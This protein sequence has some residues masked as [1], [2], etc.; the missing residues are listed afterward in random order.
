MTEIYLIRH[1][2]AE[3]NVFRMMQ[4]QWDGDVTDMGVRQIDALAE[5]LKDTHFGAVYS[6]DLYRTRLTA[7]A[8]TRFHD[9]PF[10]TT[11]NLREI[12]VGPWE[13]KYFAEL[14]H[15]NPQQT[16]SF[17]SDPEHWYLEGAE[18]YKDVTER[19]YPQ[20]VEIAEKHPGE[21]VAAVSHGITIRCAL[22]KISGIALNDLEHL[23]ICGNTA[24]TK[25]IYEDGKFRIDFFNDCSH[26]DALGGTG[27]GKA[28]ALRGESFD[29]VQDKD[30]YQDCYRDAWIA[31]HGSSEGYSNV[32]LNYAIEHYREDPEA[33]LRIYDGDKLVGLVDMDTKRGENAGYGWISLLYLRPEYRH[34][35]FG[36]QLLAR[37]LF[38]Y[39]G[40]GR[41]ALRL[42]VAEDNEAALAFY[43]KN[44]F[45]VLSWENG[46]LGKLL[47]MEKKLGGSRNEK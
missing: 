10:I 41:K 4:G 17:I 24:V 29:P 42:Q 12:N 15:K 1:A 19:V 33:V 38:K 30:W 46:S 6:S 37:P 13:T 35:G 28:E 20:I 44:G 8:I 2:Q 16:R 18:S 9:V 32:Y 26:L 7:S 14:L 27:W 34:R 36:I 3:G 47:L 11:K 39:K 31:A 43:K 40:M 23:P 45:E 5:R 21:T 22:A 25:L